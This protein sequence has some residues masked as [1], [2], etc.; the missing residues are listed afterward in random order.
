MEN[1]HEH[2]RDTHHLFAVNAGLRSCQD[3]TAEPFRGIAGKPS[4]IR[5]SLICR[6]CRRFAVCPSCWGEI[7]QGSK[8]YS[9]DKDV[10]RRSWDHQ[11]PDLVF[12]FGESYTSAYWHILSDLWFP[13]QAVLKK[14]PKEKRQVRSSDRGSFSWWANDASGSL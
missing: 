12:F 9:K 7:G 14:S 3:T 6:I 11:T 10:F 5:K 13:G 1:C 4:T 8:L 2:L